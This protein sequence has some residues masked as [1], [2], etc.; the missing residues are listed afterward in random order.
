MSEKLLFLGGT[1]TAVNL[2]ERAKEMG[3]YTIVTDYIPD[4]PGKKVADKHFDISTTDID[5]IVELVKKEKIDGI[6]L[7]PIESMM[8]FCRKI[9]DALG[10]PYY[11]S[12]KQIELM[13]NK[14]QFKRLCVQHGIHVIEEYDIRKPADIVYPVVLK[15][16]DNSGGRGISVCSG[17]SDL[18]HCCQLAQFY[19][20][21]KTVLVEKLMCSDEAV[22]YYTIQDGFI[23]LSG[24]CDRY[25]RKGET[26]LATLPTAYVFPS[27]HIKE[28]M[29]EDNRK[30]VHMFSDMNIQNGVMFVQGFVED[31]SFVAY[32]PGFRLAGARGDLIIKA[33]N[34]IDAAEMLIRHALTGKMD[35]YDIKKLDNPLFEVMAC[36]LTPIIK[37]GK[38]ARIEGVEEIG[39]M[40]GITD[41]LL[42]HQAGDVVSQEGTLDQVAA[43]IYI[44]AAHKDALAEKIDEVQ[45]L[46]HVYDDSGNDM[47]VEG[48]DTGVLRNRY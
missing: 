12:M 1:S 18:E 33:V 40:Q 35:G 17:P 31:G 9:C 38:I 4:S 44:K 2:I 8:P 22:V 27:L 6:F 42:N 45:Q 41:I 16:V 13:T 47:V 7:P 48:F 46:F 25:T 28:F 26:G 14:E 32:E 3:I 30:F 23:S 39:N 36:K 11:A 10:M 37:C 19:S 15:P 34:G 21:T 43:R 29:T 20:K 5:A 24:M